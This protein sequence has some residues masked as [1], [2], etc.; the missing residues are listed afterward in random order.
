MTDVDSLVAVSEASMAKPEVLFD[1]AISPIVLP[2]P[3]VIASTPMPLGL[4]DCQ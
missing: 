3:V 4:S 1:W 2:V